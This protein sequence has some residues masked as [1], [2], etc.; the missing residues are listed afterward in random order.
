VVFIAFA[1]VQVATLSGIGSSLAARGQFGD[2]FGLL[3]ALFNGLAFAGLIITITL[4]SRELRLQRFELSATRE[5]MRGQKEQLEYQSFALA[6]QNFEG[7]FFRLLQ[8]IDERASALPDPMPGDLSRRGRTGF[9]RH[10]EQLQ[11]VQQGALSD[12]TIRR[13]RAEG[14]YAAWFR[15]AA[16]ELSSYFQL[17]VEIT[18]FVD[19]T[20]VGVDKARYLSLVRAALSPAE[21][22]LLYYHS[23]LGPIGAD[24]ARVMHKYGLHNSPDLLVP[25]GHREWS[26]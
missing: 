23:L 25:D 10:L 16:P 20:Q 18:Q 14:V 9:I 12:P 11:R 13:D 7:T 22:S 24:F 19:T 15:S 17:L 26:R 6:K 2:A 4:Q 5:E 21:R 8:M 1:G 3:S